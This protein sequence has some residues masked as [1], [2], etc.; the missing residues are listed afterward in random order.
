VS[1]MKRIKIYSFIVAAGML[2]APSCTT[3]FVDKNTNPNAINDVTPNLLLPGIMRTAINEMV[4]QS[5]GIGNIVIQHT[6][7][8]QFVSEDRYT[9]GDRSGLW[10]NMYSNLRNV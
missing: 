9:W 6:A 5:W 7:K 1:D 4:N 2:F 8:I 10:N 3:D